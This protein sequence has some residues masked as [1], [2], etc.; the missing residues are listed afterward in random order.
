MSASVYQQWATASAQKYGVPTS[1]FLAQIGQESSWNP[2]AVG[3]SLAGG[4]PQGIAQFTPAT[5]ARFGIDPF[6]PQQALD[7][8]A[9]YDAQLYHQTGTWTGALRSYGTLPG[10]GNYSSGQ[11]NVASIA[12]GLDAG[13]PQTG[14][15]VGGSGMSG[16][17]TSTSTSGGSGTAAGSGLFADVWEI[18][19]RG[20]VFLMG[21]SLVLVAL[22]ALLSQSKTV[23]VAASTLGKVA[24]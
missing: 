21:L 7:A 8:A 24:V 15:N 12:A 1:L 10:N 19:L 13:S 18:A 17:S 5:A 6:D 22:F 16:T 14:P 23:Q 11:Q 3:P 4:A 9:K 20:G 2:F